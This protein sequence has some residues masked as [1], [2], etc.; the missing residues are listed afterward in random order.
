MSVVKGNVL[1]STA[2]ILRRGKERE[3]P[4]AKKPTYLRKVIDI[5]LTLVS[6]VCD[7]VAFLGN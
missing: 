5:S 7:Y 1:D 3:E 4:K 6:C 2:P